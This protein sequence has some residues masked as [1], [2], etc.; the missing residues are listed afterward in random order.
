[1][2]RQS[3]FLIFCLALTLGLLQAYTA[4]RDHFSPVHE[5]ARE[6]SALK[7]E[8]EREKL[9]TAWAEQQHLDFQQ[10]V[11]QV[12]PNFKNIPETPKTLG[13]RGLAS[14]TQKPM[15][16]VDF[17][18]G[19]LDQAKA[20][21]RQGDYLA[22]T[23]E[24]RQLIQKYPTSPL[25]IESHFFLAEGYFL[26]GK[27]QECL[28]VVDHMLAFYP[29]HDLTGFI[30]LRQGQVLEGRHRGEEAAEVYSVIKKKFS[31]NQE[32]SS[33]ADRLLKAVSR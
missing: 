12:L 32:L 2:K 7:M 25:V 24:F 31:H 3:L 10:E 16:S 26:A 23:K 1:M 30:L 27:Y 9:K 14:V 11:A 21:F 29:E 15:G 20:S 22:A 13:L 5:Q 19:L 4:F 18:R 6:I 28:D 33:Q 8:V 17:S